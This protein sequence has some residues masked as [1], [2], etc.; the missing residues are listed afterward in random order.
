MNI[1]LKEARAAVEQAE[2]Y[3]DQE[4]RYQAVGEAIRVSNGNPSAR[5]LVR[6]ADVIFE[7]IKS[8]KLPKVFVPK[9]RK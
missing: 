7:F 1:T 4:L 3:H 6:E 9:V 8:G 5:Q 2:L